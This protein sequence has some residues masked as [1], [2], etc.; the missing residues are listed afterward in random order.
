MRRFPFL[1]GL[2][3]IA[4]PV[5][6]LAEVP[7][8]V[9]DFGP[10]QSL[11]AQVMGDLGQPQVLLAAGADPHDFQMKPSQARAL[12]EAELV[13]WVGP[14]LMPAMSDAI[15]ALG[16]EENVV[17]LLEDGGGEIR[18]YP[19]GGIDPHAWLDPD[20]AEAWLG[21]IAEEL[22]NKDPENADTYAA[23]AIAAQATIRDLDTELQTALEP[24]RDKPFVVFHDAMG[25][26]TDHFGLTPAG[27]IELGDASAPSAAQ[28]DEIREAIRQTNAVCVFPEAGRD[29]KFVATVVEGSAAR[30]GQPQDIE[31][32]TLPQGPGQYAA[33]MRGIAATLTE[34]LGQ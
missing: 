30:T 21:A 1:A 12:A 10:V 23:N 17:A 15:T 9:V 34:C 3:L 28:L 31:G 18:L 26:F 22:S 19:E 8:V 14:D 13:F 24:V 29:P 11:V 20:N 6:L 16:N 25:Y 33:L 4:L 27:A 5:P 7:R 2:A 32:I